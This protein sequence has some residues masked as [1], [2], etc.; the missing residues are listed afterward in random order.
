M[1]LP[2]S[3][4]S[5]PPIHPHL[6]PTQQSQPP[7]P[8]TSLQPQSLASPSP[9]IS[10]PPSTSSSSMPSLQSTWGNR[11]NI[12]TTQQTNEILGKLPIDNVVE[13][14][15]Y[16]SNMRRFRIFG[17]WLMVGQWWAMPCE[18]FFGANNFLFPICNT[19]FKMAW[20]QVPSRVQRSKLVASAAVCSQ[21]FQ[22]VVLF[23]RLSASIHC[24]CQPVQRWQQRCSSTRP[25]AATSGWGVVKRLKAWSSSRHKTSASWSR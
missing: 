13:H 23:L 9:A 8:T 2:T 19:I 6:S 25:Q 4:C 16:P 5:H 1:P 11:V 21:A 12:T 7:P 3:I 10:T 22:S 17:L 24:G 20:G 18:L 15:G 14:R